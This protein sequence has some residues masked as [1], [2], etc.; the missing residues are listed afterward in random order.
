MFAKRSAKLAFL[1]RTNLIPMKEG[2]KQHPKLDVISRNTG[3]EYLELI[4]CT[5]LIQRPISMCAGTSQD[6]K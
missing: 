3:K 6:L 1:F 2:Q 5:D 4:C